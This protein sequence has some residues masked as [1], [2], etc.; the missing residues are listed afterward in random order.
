MMDAGRHPRIQLHTLAEVVG[1]QG[2]AGDFKARVRRQPRYVDPEL[3]IA[4]GLC[5]E[6]C[7]AVRPNPYDA[8]LKAA[9]AIDRP[10]PQAVPATYHI[11]REAC[12]NDEFLVC[13]RCVKACEPDAINFDDTAAE[14]TLDV[15]AVVVATGFDELDPTELQA[16]GYGRAPNVMTG[17]EF[18]RLLCATGPTRGR[19]LR[20]SDN[21]VPGR[22]VFVQCVGSRGEGGRPYC[23]RY[24]CM[25]SVK[26]A[27]LA[28]E[29]EP[30]L[31]ECVLLYTDMRAVGRGYDAFVKRCL[32]RDDI[33]QVRGR[34]AK[35]QENPDTGDLTVWVEDF[36]TG[37]PEKLEAGM[38]VLSTAA[39]PAYGSPELAEI[40]GVELDL[41]GFYRRRDP[42]NV[43]TELSRPGIHVAG[44][45]GAPAI[46]PECV[47]QGG[48]AAAEAAVHVLDHRQDT[49]EA[50]PEE[51]RD[52]GG[53]PRVGVFV[54]HCGANIAGVVD[55]V[56]LA[57]EARGMPGVVYATDDSFACA[58]ISQRAIAAAIA[59]HDLNRVVVA[60]C[61]PR[62][63]EPVFREVL[64]RS[65]LNPYLVEM[66]NIRDQCTW[67]HA[68]VPDQ[69]YQ[70]ARDQ[71]RMGVARAVALEPLQAV[72]VAVNRRALVVGGGVAGIRAALDLDAQGY[73]VDLIE[74]SGQL[75]GILTDPGLETLYGSGVSGSEKLAGLS[76]PLEKSGVTVRVNTELAAVHGYLG[77]FRVELAGTGKKKVAAEL[78]LGTI[79]LATGAKV[80]DPAGKFEYGVKR[81]VVTS[82]ELEKKLA[83]PKDKQ[84]GD[85][86]KLPASAVFIQC[87]GSRQEGEGCNPGCSR[88]CCP[89]T[90]DQALKLSRRG[91]KTTVLYR[92]MR[93][94]S[95]GAEEMYRKARGEGVLF[96]RVPDD[97]PPAVVGTK[98]IA[99]GVV[100]EDIMLGRKIEAPA[101]LVVLAVGLV[102]D[103]EMVTHLKEIL[104]V[105]VGPDGFFMERHPELGPVETVVDGVFVCGSAVGAKAISESLSE[106]AAAAGKA[107]QVMVR[108]KL[109][110]EPTIAEVD[111][112]RCRGCGTCLEICEFH[113]PGLQKGE[114]GV[115]V[116]L[117]NKASCKGCGTCVAWCPS[118]AIT[119]R[120]FT[121][122]QIETMMTTMLQWEEAQ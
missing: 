13:E 15:G 55:P 4:C 35:I 119:A 22:V 17:L 26:S 96:I 39:L 76:G 54:C 23:S 103:T 56:E 51:I 112:L 100:A 41:Q 74:K 44:S 80:F 94:V 45:A 70:R 32:D 122:N 93:C 48:A 107:G 77:N 5:S 99:K 114:L 6:A 37:R 90:V 72:E 64:A 11:D 47:A 110:L 24:C 31:E 109:A 88:Y 8:G 16:F 36:R 3:C 121:D 97:P 89:A 30:S 118:G 59:E 52:P 12:L 61:T 86:G 95:S 91:V 101:D 92:D 84:F 7:P 29:H 1:L 102:P 108:R 117:I 46:V 81:N 104:K 75:G 57:T 10:F 21:Q 120:H 18:E 98:T 83:S 73:E 14:I 49:E 25:N 68:H 34:P 2:T 33:R 43:P 82:V 53:E 19:V 65:G 78:E 60:A 20:P 27:M 67:V 87:V 63:H 40:L 79:I 106:A 116:A 62:T 115:P 71:I 85:G 113:A 50:P 66:V 28:H 111:P 9:K 58:D 42:E 38:V 69:A 105:P